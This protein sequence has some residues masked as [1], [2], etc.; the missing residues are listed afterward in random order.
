MEEAEWLPLFRAVQRLQHVMRSAIPDNAPVN[1]SQMFTL[2]ALRDKGVQAPPP[3][4]GPD[5]YAPMTLSSLARVMNQTAPALSQRITQLEEM[6]YVRRLPDSRDR[7]TVRVQLTEQGMEL[8]EW[9]G[10]EFSARI[11][12]LA[13]LLGPQEMNRMAADFERLSSAVEEVFGAG[14]QAAESRRNRFYKGE[15]DSC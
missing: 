6:G 10:R 4:E 11:E 9:A 2:V 15:K 1:R 7:R 5:S 12:R 13:A 14:R 8:I 3:R